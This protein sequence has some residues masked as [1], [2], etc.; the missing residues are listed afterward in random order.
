[1]IHDLLVAVT[2]RLQRM[3]RGL[4]NARLFQHWFVR[5]YESG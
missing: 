4:A 5:R 1:V 3:G 2:E